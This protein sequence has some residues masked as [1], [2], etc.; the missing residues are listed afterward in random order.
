M[1]IACKIVRVVRDV[2][3]HMTLLDE[4]SR[5]CVPPW[6]DAELRHKLESANAKASYE[7]W[8]ER[9]RASDVRIVIGGGDDEGQ[10]EPVPPAELIEVNGSPAKIP[11]N[12]SRML[13]FY[14]RGTPRLNLMAH[15]VE[16]PD[17]S[18]ISDTDEVHIQGWLAAQPAMLRVLVG[19]EAVHAGVLACAEERPF[20]PVREYLAGLAWDGKPRI[21]GFARDCLGAVDGV[22]VQHYM[23]C[24]FVGAV[25]RAMNPGCQLDTVLVLEGA[26]GVR[27]TTALRTLFGAK[28]FGNTPINVKKTPDCYQALEGFWGYELGELDAHAREAAAAKAFVSMRE[29]TYRPSYGRNTVSRL[30]QVAFTATTNADTYLADET[31]ARRYQCLRCGSVDIERI[32]QERDQLWAEAAHRYASGET[33]WLDSETEVIAAIDVDSRYQG[34]SWE[35]LLP[36]LLTDHATVTSAAALVLLGVEPGKHARGDAMRVGAALRRCGWVRY[37]SSHGARHYEYAR[38]P[39]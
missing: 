21:E 33:W 25:A 27:K 29:D 15:R 23:R 30:R 4:Y 9:E 2:S 19:L 32:A 37:R 22:L 5:T 7:G 31:G 36:G 10:G 13:A 34:D 35:V 38:G 18:R 6:S 1:T 24:F 16:W 39:T 11:S 12:V 14:P 8:P 26:Q 17:G 28:W 20:H 3:Q